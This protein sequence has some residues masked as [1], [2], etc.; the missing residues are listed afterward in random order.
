MSH[1]KLKK[2]KS[3]LS[4]LDWTE[5]AKRISRFCPSN[6]AFLEGDTKK[7]KTCSNETFRIYI[8]HLCCIRFSVGASEITNKT[9]EESIVPLKS[10]ALLFLRKVISFLAAGPKGIKRMV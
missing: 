1:K 4:T 9:F 10:H 7:Q 3:L 5:S 2:S 8:L 6:T